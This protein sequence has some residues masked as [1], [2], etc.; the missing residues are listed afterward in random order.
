M[1]VVA[2]NIYFDAVRPTYHRSHT[3]FSCDVWQA[4]KGRDPSKVALLGTSA[5]G[6]LA[7]ATVLRLKNVSP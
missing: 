2:V 1:V 4:V 6:G 7:M 5:G 3:S